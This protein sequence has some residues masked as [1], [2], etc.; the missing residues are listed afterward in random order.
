[1]SDETDQFENQEPADATGS[2][3]GATPSGAEE[4]TG[5]VPVTGGSSV[6]QGTVHGA[7][8]VPGSGVPGSGVPCP[9]AAEPGMSSESEPAAFTVIGRG[10]QRLDDAAVRVMRIGEWI[11]AAVVAVLV[12]GGLIAMHLIFEPPAAIKITI[13]VVAELVVLAWAAWAHVWPPVYCRRVSY[14]V[15]ELGVE[16][17]RGVL[18][19]HLVVVPRSRIQHIDVAQGPI[20]R[21]HGLSTL[22]LHTAGTLNSSVSL[23]GIAREKAL[24]IRDYLTENHGGDDAV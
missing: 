18:F 20:Q 8:G 16:I 13:I 1:M 23:T 5:A 14:R 3:A 22:T 9:E 15:D 17:R 24:E 4:W 11:G 19:R 12:L 7:P 21:K 6:P 2:A 10:R